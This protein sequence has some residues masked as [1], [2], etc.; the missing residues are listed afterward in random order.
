MKSDDFERFRH[1]VSNAQ[2]NPFTGQPAFP[3]FILGVKRMPE[4]GEYKVTVKIGDSYDEGKANYIPL[5]Y[6][7]KMSQLV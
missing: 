2:I 4:W 6:V 5:E 1:L 3:N 7:K